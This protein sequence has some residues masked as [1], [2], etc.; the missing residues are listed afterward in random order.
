MRFRFRQQL[1]GE[2]KSELIIVECN[3]QQWGMTMDDYQE[4][5]LTRYAI[6]WP[7]DKEYILVEDGNRAHGLKNK[8]MQAKKKKLGIVPLEDWPPSSPD[9]NVIEKIWRLLKQRLKSRRVIS[10]LEALKVA[11]QEEWERLT[12][13]EIQRLIVTMPERVMEAHEKNGLATRF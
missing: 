6:S 4:Q 5:I 9:F 8:R 12:Q 10:S 11:L 3:G 1:D 2:Y 7:K 13:E